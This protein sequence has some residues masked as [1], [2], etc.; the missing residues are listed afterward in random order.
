MYNFRLSSF[1]T[2]LKPAIFFFGSTMLDAS[3]DVAVVEV[4]VECVVNGE[5]FSSRDVRDIS[6]ISV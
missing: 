2:P 6:V 4:V 1:L 3:A 5:E